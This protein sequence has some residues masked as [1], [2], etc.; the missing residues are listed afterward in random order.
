MYQPTDTTNIQIWQIRKIQEDTFYYIQIF[1][2]IHVHT[3]TVS[4]H[5]KKV[6]SLPPHEMA[7]AGI[8]LDKKAE[9]CMAS[10]LETEKR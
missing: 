8:P 7:K 4:F 2:Q 5:S 1:V 10:S 6:I 9:F 3:N